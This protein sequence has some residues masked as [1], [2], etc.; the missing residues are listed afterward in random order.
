MVADAKPKNRSASCHMELVHAP[1]F[2]GTSGGCRPSMSMGRPPS[3]A[4]PRCACPW[5]LDARRAA[6][7]SSRQTTTHSSHSDGKPHQPAPQRQPRRVLRVA[8][9]REPQA[10]RID[11]DVLQQPEDLPGALQPGRMHAPRQGPRARTPGRPPRC[12]GRCS[13]PP[14]TPLAVAPRGPARRT[15]K[16]LTDREGAEAEAAGEADAAAHGRVVPSFVRGAGIEQDE[17]ECRPLPPPAP[18]AVAEAAVA[19]EEG[20]AVHG[21][22]STARLPGGGRVGHIRARDADDR[23]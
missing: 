17:A 14:G 2:W 20:G 10:V 6:Q 18:E 9:R 7:R 16:R 22:L 3:P 13:A 1:T 21:R 23:R 12:A 8:A 11:A 15:R 4:A 5:F 19:G